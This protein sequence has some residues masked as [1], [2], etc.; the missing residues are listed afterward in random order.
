VENIMSQL[1]DSDR[2]AVDCIM[3][4]RLSTQ[5]SP[6]QSGPPLPAERVSDAS[7]AAV[8]RIVDLLT[9]CPV[10]DPPANLAQR[11][12][13]RIELG[14]APARRAEVAAVASLPV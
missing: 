1:N 3:Q 12:L 5:G 2:C 9:S 13:R 4:L 11:T 14:E 6:D 10:A 7:L 8:T